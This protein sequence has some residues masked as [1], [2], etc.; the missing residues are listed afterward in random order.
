MV[1]PGLE[2]PEGGVSNFDN[3]NREMYYICIA[4]NIIAIVVC[5]VFVVLR[6]FARYRLATKVSLDDVACLLGYIGYMGNNGLCLTIPFLINP[7]SAVLRYGGGLHQWDVP[8]PLVANYHKVVYATMVN[9]G[10]MA[11]ATKAAILL[12]L[13]RVFSPFKIYC[14]WI[15]GFIGLM[16]LYYIIMLFLKVFICTPISMFWGEMANGRCFNQ[17][18]LTLVDNVISL[19]SDLAVLL[20]PCPLTRSLQVRLK[21]KI[22]VGLVFGI[23]G[24]A[25]VFSLFRLVLIV[26]YGESLD[27]TYR[28]V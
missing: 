1:Q 9:Y 26:N 17:R 27:S 24:I 13:T 7:P 23:G 20:L 22:K 4:S 16:A 10:S 8:A 3:P 2:T 25:C 21:S 14:R 18:I 12:F 5:S 19:I 11:F 15:Y 6:F 28:F